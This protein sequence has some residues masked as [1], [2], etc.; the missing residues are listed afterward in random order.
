MDALNAL[1][2]ILLPVA[3]GLLFEELTLGGLVRLLLAP[4]PKSSRNGVH[5]AGNCSENCSSLRG[6]V[7]PTSRN[8]IGGA[9]C[10]H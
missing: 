5:R 10:L 7:E 8:E 2:A 9:K 1:N 6:R 3:G 4:R